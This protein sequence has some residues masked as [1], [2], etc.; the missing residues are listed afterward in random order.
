VIVPNAIDDAEAFSTAEVV[1]VPLRVTSMV[2]SIALLVIAIVPVSAAPA[3]GLNATVIVVLCPAL[4]AMGRCG[5]DAVNPAPAT[6]IPE[7][8]KMPVPVFVKV[9]VFVVL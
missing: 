3:V 4:S 8:I 2:G 5:P 6:E 1:P 7:I 9:T